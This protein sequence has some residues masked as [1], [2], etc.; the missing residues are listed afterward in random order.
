M[1]SCCN[2]NVFDSDRKSIPSLDSINYLGVFSNE[3]YPLKDANHGRILNLETNFAYVPSDFSDFF[4][5]K[6]ENLPGQDN[7]VFLG[8]QLSSKYD[9]IGNRSLPIDLVVLL[10]VSGSMTGTL[11]DGN[12]RCIDLAKSAI[13]K[14]KLKLK[15]NDRISLITFDDRSNVIFDLN[16]TK[17]ISEFEKQVNDIGLGGSTIISVGMDKC[18]EIMTS[19]TNLLNENRLKRILLLTDM[20]DTESNDELVLAVQKCSEN[21]IFISIIGIGF[22][23]NFSLTEKI[24]KTKGFN[25]FSAIKEED[26]DNI[27]VKNFDLNF[28][29]IAYDINL[30]LESGDLKIE[31]VYGTNFNNKLFQLEKEWTTSE[32]ILSN[33]KIKNNIMFLLLFFRRKKSRNLPMPILS[34]FIKFLQY[35]KKTK[36]VCEISSCTATDKNDNQVKGKFFMIKCSLINFSKNFYSQFESKCNVKINLSYKNI[37][38]EF[39]SQ[40]YFINLNIPKSNE[41]LVSE[42]ISIGLSNFYFAKFIRKIIRSYENNYDEKYKKFLTEENLIS[43]RKSLEKVLDYINPNKNENSNNQDFISQLFLKINKLIVDIL[44]DSNEQTSN[45]KRYLIDSPRRVRNLSFDSLD[46]I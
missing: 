14:L 39:Y 46:E 23:L 24:S 37:Q 9:G 26:L 31:K 42:N 10:D 21:N 32:H 19:Q 33:I 25:Y 30:T 11:Q 12:Q 22:D 45:K 35:N 3:F 17:N 7:N 4:H 8:C 27:I 29:P 5:E 41:N 1:N 34:N 36:N 20:N 6:Q 40:E 38:N 18:F 28:F 16:Y 2:F 43:T 13:L 15:N 44:E